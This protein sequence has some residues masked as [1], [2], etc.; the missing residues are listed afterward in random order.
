MKL[1]KA[2]SIIKSKKFS[3][4]VYENG[5]DTYENF[6]IERNDN[7]KLPKIKYAKAYVTEIIPCNDKV[8]VAI[9]KGKV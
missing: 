4:F 1:K 3:I 2:L 9:D 7:G 6:N 8:N 5:V